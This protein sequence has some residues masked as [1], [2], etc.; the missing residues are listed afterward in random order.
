[1]LSSPGAGLASSLGSVGVSQPSTNTAI[2]NA[3]GHI[4]PSSMQRAY[5]ALGLPYGNQSPGQ[6]QV[7]GQAS[8]QGHPTLRSINSLSTVWR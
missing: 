5:A 3:A 1:M 8:P 4:D 6:T 7:P 2:N